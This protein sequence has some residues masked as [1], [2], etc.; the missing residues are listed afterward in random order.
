MHCLRIERR[1]KGIGHKKKTF[2]K[3]SS[4]EYQVLFLQFFLRVLKIFTVPLL[5]TELP[6]FLSHSGLPDFS[7][8]KIPKR[9]KYT[10]LP[11][12]NQMSIKYNKRL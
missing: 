1:N 5:K 4:D 10:K 8:Y 12:T 3:R 7:W 2:F 11:R 9:E 6:V